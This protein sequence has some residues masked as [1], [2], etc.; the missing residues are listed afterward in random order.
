MKDFKLGFWQTPFVM[1]MIP[2]VFL[3]I[4]QLIF[5]IYLPLIILTIFIFLTAYKIT[6]LMTDNFHEYIDRRLHEYIDKHSKKQ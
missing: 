3:L 5:Y 2:M 4:V 6:E 1:F